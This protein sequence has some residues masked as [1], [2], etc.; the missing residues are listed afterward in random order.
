MADISKITL[1]S[2]TTYDIKDATARAAVAGGMLAFI[3]KPSNLYSDNGTMEVLPANFSDGNTTVKYVKLSGAVNIRGT[4]YASGSIYKV[5]TGDTMIVGDSEYVATVSG[6]DPSTTVKWNEFGSTSSLGALAFENDGSVTFAPS[7]SVDVYGNEVSAN[8]VAVTGD[9][10]DYTPSGT[11]SQPSFSGTELTSTGTFTATGSVTLSN[12]NVT[13]PVSVDSSSGAVA[14]YTPAGSV[15]APT[16]S[17]SSAGSTGT[18]KNPTSKTV[19]TDMDVADASATAATGEL[20]YA[21]VSNET[22]TLKKFVETRGDSITTSN[23]TVKTGDASYTATAPAFTG[24]GVRLVTGDI[25]V[26]SSASFSGTTNQAISVKGTPSGTV[27]QPTFTGDGVDIEYQT[28]TSWT[29]D[30]TGTSQ[31]VEVDFPSQAS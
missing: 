8:H 6:T 25:S 16:I 26:P 5:Q 23:V 24:T 18:I 17:V 9:G 14:T 12:S 7:G 13:A 19:V 11:V 2:G 31:T 15:A 30:F 28:T 22:L 27:S 4:S 29:A 20:V 10:V 1:P 3:G 21:S